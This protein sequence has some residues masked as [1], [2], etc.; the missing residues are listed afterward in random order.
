MLDKVWTS[1]SP[2]EFHLA[3]AKS[4]AS[5]EPEFENSSQMILR[6]TPVKDPITSSL[7][8]GF[9]EGPCKDMGTEKKD[10]LNK[11]IRLRPLLPQYLWTYSTYIFGTQD[12]TERG[13]DMYLGP[14]LRDMGQKISQGWKR[15]EA[16]HTIQLAWP[17]VQQQGFLYGLKACPLQ[18]E[19][20][21]CRN[22]WKSALGSWHKLKGKKTLPSHQ[23]Q[24]LSSWWA[25]LWKNSLLILSKMILEPSKKRTGD[26]RGLLLS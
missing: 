26:T 25:G 9:L 13:A 18:N 20:G 23:P 21:I 16:L 15:W 11:N 2:W 14:G 17:L 24:L 6:Y 12:L 10:N 19:A 22:T 1:E 7:S 5:M 8:P 4:V 3:T